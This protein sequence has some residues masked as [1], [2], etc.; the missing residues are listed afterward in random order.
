V[1]DTGAAQAG[2]GF[3]FNA[4]ITVATAGFDSPITL[5]GIGQALA[6]KAGQMIEN[7][8]ANTGGLSY[9]APPGAVWADGVDGVATDAEIDA[10]VSGLPRINT[11]TTKASGQF[12]VEQTGPYNYTV[13]AGD[14]TIDIDGYDGSTILDAKFVQKPN[15]SPYVNGSDA[16]DFV[17]QIVLE[18]QQSEF[19]RFSMAINDPT[20]PFDSLNILTNE[21]K[22]VPYFQSLIDQYQ[23]PGSV[24]VV[25]TNIPQILPG[26]KQ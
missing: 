4:G 8:M 10:Y 15:V 25:P 3:V 20:V 22:A 17:R 11:P 14:D 26:V 13:P 9:A 2:G 21:P 6:P 24:T 18:E 1:Q 19:Q 16:P 7:Y 5:D 23:I 12:E